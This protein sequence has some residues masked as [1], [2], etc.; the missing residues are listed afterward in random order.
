M[1]EGWE[2]VEPGVVP[3]HDWHPAG[4]ETVAGQLLGGVGRLT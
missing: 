3:I 4:G 2:V 1:F